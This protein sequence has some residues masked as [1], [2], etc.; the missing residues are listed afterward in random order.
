MIL[1]LVSYNRP[2]TL[3]LLCRRILM[4]FAVVCSICMDEKVNAELQVE[5]TSKHCSTYIRTIHHYLL[6]SK[7]T[8][9]NQSIT[10]RIVM[11]ISS[12]ALIVVVVHIT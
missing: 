11:K 9:L 12:N 6:A 8:K 3:E 5:R 4:N 2:S 10:M 1:I 7:A